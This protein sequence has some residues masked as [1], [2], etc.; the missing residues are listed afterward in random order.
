METEE[1]GETKDRG[2]SIDKENTKDWNLSL[3][4]SYL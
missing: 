2:H 4:D 3:T 1:S